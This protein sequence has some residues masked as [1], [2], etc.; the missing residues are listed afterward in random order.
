M[1]ELTGVIQPI[2]AWEEIGVLRTESE[3]GTEKGEASLFREVFQNAVDQVRITQEDVE[4]KQYLLAS[5]Q[6]DDA[7]TL[8]IA[9]TKATL[10]VELLVSLRNKALEAYNDLMKMSV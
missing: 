2:R 9:Q 6:L 5:G 4:N 10:S 3:Q 7:H 8:P 1:E